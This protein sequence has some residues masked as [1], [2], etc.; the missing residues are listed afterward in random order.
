MR[1]LEGRGGS[2]PKA[3]TVGPVF[4]ITRRLWHGSSLIVVPLL[5]SST[6]TIALTDED[7][8]CRKSRSRTLRGLTAGGRL[9]GRTDRAC[10]QTVQGYRAH[11]G[12]ELD[13]LEAAISSC[14]SSSSVQCSTSSSRSIDRATA[15]HHRAVRPAAAAPNRTKQVKPQ[16]QRRLRRVTRTGVYRE[17]A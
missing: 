5:R 7:P 9:P 13:N 11:R 16:D 15:G 2:R 12:N 14:S 6:E 8:Q 17:T 3:G 10:P 1:H 4:V